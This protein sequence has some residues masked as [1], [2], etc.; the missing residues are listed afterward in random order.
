MDV[1]T[2]QTLFH[3]RVGRSPKKP[4]RPENVP[5]GEYLYKMR[6]SSRP[7][8]QYAPEKVDVTSASKDVS[9]RLLQKKRRVRYQEIFEELNPDE[10]QEISASR[11]VVEELDRDV[12]LIIAP[13]LEELESLKVTLNFAEFEEAMDALVKTLNPEQKAKLLCYAKREKGGQTE[14]THKPL[15]NVYSG[16]ERFRQRRQT[17]FYKRIMEHKQQIQEKLEAQKLL[18]EEK[19]LKECSFQPKT[20]P[21]AARS[22]HLLSDSQPDLS[23]NSWFLV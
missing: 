17:P 2:G 20:I 21:Y 13:L 16:S 9:L 1:L 8:S 6:S 23:P 12:L 18:K 3:P 19:E 10:N 22:A 5:V 14:D 4:R 15:T 11:V 7:K